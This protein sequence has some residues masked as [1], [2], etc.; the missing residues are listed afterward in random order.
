MS[1]IKLTPERLKTIRPTK[2]LEIRTTNE[3]TFH[4]DGLFSTETFGPLGSPQ[5]N[6]MFSYIKVHT[7]VFHPKYYK[8]LIRLK[9]QYEGILTGK[10]YAV[11][12][13]NEKD[14]VTSDAITG[15]TG[16]SFFI[17]NFHKLEF[18]RNNSRQ[19]N[20]RIDFIEKYRQDCFYTEILV[21]PAGLRDIVTGD[22][23]RDT[24]GEINEFYRRILSASNSI[25]SQADPNSPLL[26]TSR[27]AIQTAFNNI[28]DYISGLLKG[29]RGF[30]AGKWAKR[31][32]TTTTR[33]VITSIRTG[34]AV[35]GS[36]DAIGYNSTAVGI[37]Q[38][39]KSYEP[40]IIHA[41]LG[42]TNRVFTQNGAMLIDKN[43]LQMSVA[44]LPSEVIDL[45]AT[46]TG[47]TKLIDRFSEPAFRLKPITV[48]TDHYLALIWLGK[49]NGKKCFNIVLD[50]SKIPSADNIVTEVV[51]PITYVELFYLC[52]LT[53]WDKDIYFITR[54]PVTGDGSIYPSLCY[55]RT[56]VNSE[57]RYGVDDM[58][59]IDE[60]SV[61]KSYPIFDENGFATFSDSLSVHPSRLDGLG[62][63]HDG[64][65]TSSQ[66]IFS[67]EA[68]REV[69]EYLGSVAAYRDGDGN[70][71]ADPY[72]DAVKRVLF[73][74]TG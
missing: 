6:K 72:V 3:G 40:L 30:V 17:K 48:G 24:E 26:D 4:P 67:E 28:Y 27:C 7:K 47:I 63:D 16:Y 43:T 44:S 59:G 46:P 1:L 51:R 61:A 55:L 19:R 37:F 42:F 2:S 73:N 36:G 54:Y 74:I 65:K 57:T 15:D 45:W 62:G 53:E 50:K 29:K 60:M 33:S 13:E 10:I 69:Y 64:D 68:R 25:A 35:L 66:S 52:R 18:K 41:L 70:W 9:A 14:F 49:I 21:L 58:W 20:L 22:D 8:E 34:S 39:C 31:N 11:F 23:G 32:I 38:A 12:D 5:R 56:T 71:I